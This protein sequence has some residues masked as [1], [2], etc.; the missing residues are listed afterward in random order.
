MKREKREK[1]EIEREK[2]KRKEPTLLDLCEKM[3]RENRDE[4]N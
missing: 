4:W 3:K 2:K 1:D